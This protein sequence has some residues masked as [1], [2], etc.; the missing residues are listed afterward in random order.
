MLLFCVTNAQA[1]SG[2]L[3][4]AVKLGSKAVQK[5]TGFLDDLAKK[6]PSAADDVLKHSPGAL[7]DLAKYAKK[8][9][10][11]LEAGERNLIQEYTQETLIRVNGKSFTTYELM[12]GIARDVINWK[13]IGRSWYRELLNRSNA[14]NQILGRAALPKSATVWRGSAVPKEILEKLSYDALGNVDLGGLKGLK[15]MEKGIMSTSKKQG[16]AKKFAFWE[17]AAS[18]S[19]GPVKSVLY[20][21]NAPKGAK[22][23]DVSLLSQFA[24][25]EVLF[26]S[27]QSLLVKEAR[28]SNGILELAVDL[29]P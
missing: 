16:I 7:D 23:L 10:G 13:S 29:I 14:L 3:D 26:A 5:T 6:A 11:K 28:V 19:K 12:N 4:D 20:K 9:I 27:S 8:F 2:W 15:Y 1:F 21:I 24:E 18:G 22:G 25:C 17:A